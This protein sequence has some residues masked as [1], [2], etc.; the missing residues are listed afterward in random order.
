M[1]YIY[2]EAIAVKIAPKETTGSQTPLPL[3]HLFMSNKTFKMTF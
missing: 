2:L 1:K 3:N